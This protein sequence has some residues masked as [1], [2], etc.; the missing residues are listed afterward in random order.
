MLIASLPGGVVR[1]GLQISSV[2]VV[3]LRQ[4]RSFCSDLGVEACFFFFVD[5]I[6][7]Q[8]ISKLRHSSEKPGKR[9]QRCGLSF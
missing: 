4:K 1:L 9:V 2:W 8:L 6:P 3:K 5:W 7:C